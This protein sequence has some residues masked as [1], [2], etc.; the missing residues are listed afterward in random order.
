MKS[1]IQY[2]C[3]MTWCPKRCL[4]IV[5]DK[6]LRIVTPVKGKVIRDDVVSE[7]IVRIHDKLSIV[8]ISTS[9]KARGLSNLTEKR[10]FQKK[11]FQNQALTLA[12]NLRMASFTFF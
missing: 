6:R 2:K 12:T 11:L 10:A 9:F 7:E 3:E 5:I 8:K 4:V 1:Y